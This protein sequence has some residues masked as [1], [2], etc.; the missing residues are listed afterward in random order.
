[1]V[2]LRN[3]NTDDQLTVQFMEGK[4][5]ESKIEKKKSFRRMPKGGKSHFHQI[6][7]TY[8]CQPSLLQYQ[9]QGNISISILLSLLLLTSRKCGSVAICLISET[10]SVLLIVLPLVLLWIIT[11]LVWFHLFMF[12]WANQYTSVALNGK[13]SISS[14]WGNTGLTHHSNTLSNIHIS[15]I[16]WNSCGSHYFRNVPH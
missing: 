12:F 7:H 14:F 13:I 8:D 10:D 9:S 15:F 5:T 3:T 4:N 2:E 16:G 11:F 1:M 6:L